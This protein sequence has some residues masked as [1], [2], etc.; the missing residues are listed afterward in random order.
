MGQIIRIF[1]GCEVRIENSVKRVTVR[2]H[3][4]CRVMLNSYPEW[5]NFQFAPN[6]HYWFFFLH[7]LSSTIVFRLEYLLFYQLYT[8]ITT[9]SIKKCL[10]RLPSTTSWCH[11]RGRLTPPG[12]R[13]KYPERVKITENLVRYA[14]KGW[15]NSVYPDQTAQGLL[16][17]CHPVYI[18]SIKSTVMILTFRTIMPEQTVQTQI[19]LLRVYTV[20]HSVCII[21]T[22]YSIVE[23]HNSNYR[24]ISTNLLGVRIFREFTV[25]YV[26]D[27]NLGTKYGITSHNAFVFFRHAVPALFDG[28]LLQ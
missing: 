14:R 1:N 21:W 10:V 13:R 24:V 4:A 20:C 9:F 8:E 28:K 27:N 22:P 11:A 15:A 7:T 18:S 23:P 5:Q 19:R 16:A 6:K 12:I 2:H 17:V 26:A 25:M 3:K